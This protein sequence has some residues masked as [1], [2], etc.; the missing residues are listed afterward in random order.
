MIARFI[1]AKLMIAKLTYNRLNG[2]IAFLTAMS[3]TDVMGKSEN[4]SIKGQ[5]KSP[6]IGIELS[7]AL[8]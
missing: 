8:I 3:V 1:I 4:K 7:S 2:S 5:H 6:N